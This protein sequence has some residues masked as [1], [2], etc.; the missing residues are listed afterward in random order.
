MTHVSEKVSSYAKSVL[1]AK[2]AAMRQQQPY[3]PPKYSTPPS[4]SSLVKA[5]KKWNYLRNNYRLH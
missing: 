5:Y 4:T 3:S 2:Q 1:A